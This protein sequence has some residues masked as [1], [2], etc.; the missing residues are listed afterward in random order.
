MRAFIIEQFGD[1]GSIGERPTPEPSEGE[2]LVQVKAAG[3]NA[4][5]PVFRAGF[6][7]DWMEH[8]FPLTLGLDYAGTVAAV[9]P[10][11][12]GFAIGDEVFGAVAKEYVGDGSFAEYVTALASV[13]AR[14]PGTLPA[15]H[16]AALPVAGGVALAALDVLNASSGDTIAI[17]GAAGGV[18]GLATQLATQ[19]GLRVIAVTK[20]TNAD[21]VRDRGAADVVDYTMGDVVEQLLARQAG[22]VAGVIDLF[23]DIQG[24]LPLTAAVRP[25]GRIVSGIAFG[26]DQALAGQPV[27]GH[28]VRSAWERAGELGALAAAGSLKVDVEVLPLEQAAEAL[29]RQMSKQVRGKQVLAVRN[30][31]SA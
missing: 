6:G 10:G 22:G 14:R 5:D 11:V 8:R 4:A 9:G 30:G 27:S 3:V 17:I 12:E 25:G 13:A 2:I 19:R 26:L 20:G 28:V 18:G 24:A 31:A 1:P 16:A 21:Y 15:E 23:H 7:K 29:D